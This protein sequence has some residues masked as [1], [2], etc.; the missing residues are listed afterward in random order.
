MEDESM[1]PKP[2]WIEDEGGFHFEGARAQRFDDPGDDPGVFVIRTFGPGANADKAF[3]CICA[4]MQFGLIAIDAEEQ[5]RDLAKQLAA[6]G[7]VKFA[8][9]VG[10]PFKAI[11]VAAVKTAPAPTKGAAAPPPRGARG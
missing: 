9:F 3:E 4:A 2:T 5:N 8:P 6:D 1:Q 10:L 11:G 7:R